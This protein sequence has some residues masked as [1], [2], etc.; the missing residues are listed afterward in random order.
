MPC[1]GTQLVHFCQ[2][3][4]SAGCA[5]E[6]AVV[7]RADKLGTKISAGFLPGASNN[8]FRSSRN[9]EQAF[10]LSFGSPSAC[11]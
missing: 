2:Q 7:Q 8:L 6:V 11:Q 4:A 5:E 1:L 10:I 3:I 9:A